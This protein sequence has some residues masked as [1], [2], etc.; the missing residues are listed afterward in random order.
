MPPEMTL[1]LTTINVPR[2]LEG[3]L[4]NFRKYGHLGQ[5]D[6]IVVGDRKTPHAE[7]AALAQ[8][9]TA[10]G[11]SVEYMDL[12]AQR[13]YMRRFAEVDALLPFNSDQRRNIGYLKAAEQG[14]QILV[15]VD[16]DNWVRDD[17]W[18]ASHSIVGQRVRLPTV[19]CQSNWFNPCAMMDTDPPGRR[20]YTRGH[21]Y[22]KRHQD[23]G[24]RRTVTEGRVML[25]AGLWLIEPDVDS[26]TRLSE[27]VKCT[28]L[29]EERVMLEPGTWSNINTQNT[30]F[31]RDLLPAFY[32]VPITAKLG[33]IIVERYGDIWAGL[34]CRKA[35]D[36]MGDRVTYGTP[37]CDHIR[38]G[39]VL[40]KDLQ[41]EFW[42]ILITEELW[43]HIY[44]WQL[45]GRTYADV[46][47]E[48]A[49][50]LA[51]V[52]WKTVPLAD[53][54]RAYFGSMAAAMRTWAKATRTIVENVSH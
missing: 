5:V 23:D 4:E 21:P 31:H 41:L 11:F 18:F 51:T 14:A 54:V 50:R 8:R 44:G 1:V 7:N 36:V 40:L 15:A 20:L 17:D 2:L 34:L 42:A 48:M 13:V 32:F 3:Y 33:G 37:A 27:P 45:S 46:Y 24:E 30:A 35:I 47:V 16:D 29:N 12:E 22:G 26:L 25:N 28:R 53:E 19:G 43:E 49:D 39:H 38:N 9:L 52:T 6:A 10:A